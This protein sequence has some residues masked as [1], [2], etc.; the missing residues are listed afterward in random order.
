M[1]KD[2]RKT[3]H[4]FAHFIETLLKE[5]NLKINHAYTLPNLYLV[6]ITDKKTV[7]EK[8]KSLHD[9]PEVVYAEP[10]YTIQLAP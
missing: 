8:L 3:D 1:R 9:Y 2:G 5:L 10:N 7:K 4:F 6:T